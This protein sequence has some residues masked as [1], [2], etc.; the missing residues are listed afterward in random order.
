M[1]R[2]DE[3]DDGSGHRKYVERRVTIEMLTDE[4]LIT[5]LMERKRLIVVNAAFEV[6]NKHRGLDSLLLSVH[7]KLGDYLGAY[8]MA[9]H[10]AG[11]DTEQKPHAIRFSA[12]VVCLSTMEEERT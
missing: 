10:L 11:E 3:E 6:D 9:Q 7:Q 5:E 1:N 2:M 12:S 8:I 4:E